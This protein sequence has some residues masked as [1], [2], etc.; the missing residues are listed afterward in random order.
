M[1]TAL[2]N[3][4][5]MF[6]AT[7]IAK[8]LG[9]SNP[10]KAILDH[11]RYVT[12]RD[13]P[14][15]QSKNKTITMSFIPEGDVYRLIARSKLESAERFEKWVFDEVLPT[16]RKT[17]GYVSNDDLFINTYLPFADEPTKL[18]FKTTLTTIN[19]LN[20]KIEKDKPLVEFAG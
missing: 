16:I 17:G 13:T 18:L 3:D 14:H 10:R 4:K 5:I 11:C 12:K 8:S 19:Q 1:R 15:P 9:Y 20:A 7:D 6:C 2:V